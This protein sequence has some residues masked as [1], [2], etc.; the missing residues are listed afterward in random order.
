MKDLSGI[1][2]AGVGEDAEVGGKAKE[3]T[4]PAAFP[5]HGEGFCRL[6]GALGE[7]SD[8]PLGFIQV[9][10]LFLPC[11]YCGLGSWLLSISSL[12][13]PAPDQLRRTSQ[14]CGQL[15][16]LTLLLNITPQISRNFLSLS[17]VLTYPSSPSSDR[18]HYLESLKLGKFYFKPWGKKTGIIW[19]LYGM[20][21]KTISW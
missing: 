7:E 10:R 6:P 13:D 3:V 14:S 15:S 11:S 2:M 20:M 21:G 16:A 17:W 5:A 8:E 18:K 19:C 9:S 1:S 4:T 12:L